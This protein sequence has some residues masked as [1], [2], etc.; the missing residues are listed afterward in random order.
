MA[1]AWNTSFT[2][3][4]VQAL[5]KGLV[6]SNADYANLIARNYHASILTGMPIGAP[7]T[8]FPFGNATGMAAVIER[9]LNINRYNFL[10][11]DIKSQ[12]N[13]IK[14]IQA[15]IR[16]FKS[17]R[18]DITN[19]L[20]DIRSI[21]RDINQ[22]IKRVKSN[23]SRAGINQ[24]KKI[25]EV[26]TALLQYPNTLLQAELAKINN[27]V[28][29]LQSLL[30]LKNVLS[31]NAIGTKFSEFNTLLRQTFELLNG[32]IFALKTTP[33]IGRAHV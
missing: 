29:T 5:D 20:N 10:K 28:D 4:T 32:I 22:Y 6:K 24:I 15:R 8:P 9:W 13:Q 33:E 11:R 12:Y 14:I 31:F 25:S 18:K 3:P 17:V 27:N 21:E 19:Q 2:L 16:Y 1:I 26:N 7:P 30:S 23:L